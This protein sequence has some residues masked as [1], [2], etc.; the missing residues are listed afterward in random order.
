M[1]SS[2]TRLPS[3]GAVAVLLSVIIQ[4]CPAVTL[5][6][7]GVSAVYSVLNYFKHALISVTEITCRMCIPGASG[8]F[9]ISYVAPVPS[10][11]KY[12]SFNFRY[13]II[14]SYFISSH[15]SLNFRF[16]VKEPRGI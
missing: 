5:S 11:L 12:F 6:D 2:V 10:K 13:Y 7:S 4:M 9:L 3:S 16:S 15:M 1:F 14:L 8:L